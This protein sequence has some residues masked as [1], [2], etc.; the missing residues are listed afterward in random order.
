MRLDLRWISFPCSANF[1]GKSEVCHFCFSTFAQE[2]N[3]FSFGS[4]I[5]NSTSKNRQLPIGFTEVSVFCFVDWHMSNALLSSNIKSLRCQPFR[6][7]M[8]QPLYKQQ[9]Q[10]SFTS[11]SNRL[12]SQDSD[13]SPCSVEKIFNKN[14]FCGSQGI[15]WL[16]WRL[17]PWYNLV[18][19]PLNPEKS[20][21][22]YGT[23]TYP[24]GFSGARDCRTSHPGWVLAKG[25]SHHFWHLLFS[26]G[27]IMS[28]FVQNQLKHRVFIPDSVELHCLKL[29]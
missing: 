13:E 24:T 11:K 26:E 6:V 19:T 16:S 23:S 18:A 29:T 28:S 15:L 12:S 27:K 4:G 25:T 9:K 5:S 14:K 22:G 21:Y 8:V 20:P 10:K 17:G 1:V 2:K 7:H 3:V